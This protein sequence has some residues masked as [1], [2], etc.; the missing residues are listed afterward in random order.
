[1]HDKYGYLLDSNGRNPFYLRSGF[2]YLPARARAHAAW[3]QS[4][5]SEVLFPMET[6]AEM[7]AFLPSQSLLSEVWFPMCS[8]RYM[9]KAGLSQSLLSEV[10]FPIA[11][12]YDD[13]GKNGVAIPSI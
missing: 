3:S 4:L 8:E 11:T 10:W 12:I 1:M 5:L 13:S 7:Y 6:V 9:S 2:Q